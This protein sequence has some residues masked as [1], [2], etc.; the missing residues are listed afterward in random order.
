MAE[1]EFEP[2]DDLIKM[3]NVVYK[4]SPFYATTVTN[5]NSQVIEIHGDN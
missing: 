1:E 2:T 4:K 3:K 5:G